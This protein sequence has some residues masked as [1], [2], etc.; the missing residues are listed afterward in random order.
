M[1]VRPAKS[2]FGMRR[3]VG[4][5]LG[6]AVVAATFLLVLPKIANYGDVWVVVKELSW[7]AIAGLALVTF[8]NV[9]TYAPPWQAALPGLR[10]GEALAFSQAVSASGYA[11]G[12][13]AVG[14]ALAFAML[15]RRFPPRTVALGIS[16]MT[17]WNQFTLLGLPSLAVVLLAL[18]GEQNPLLQVVALVGL[19]IFVVGAGAY[20]AGLSS[21]RLARSVGNLAARW[22]SWG[23]RLVRKEPVTWSGET[24]AEFRRD[25]VALLRRRWHI[26][27]LATLVGQLTVFCV[28]LVSLRVLGVSGA[29]VSA[30][31]AFAAWSLVRLLGSI[32]I[33]PGGLGVVELGLTTALV[34]FGGENAE[35]VAAV[36]VYRFLTMVPTIL[37]GL[38]AGATW[39]RHF[40][41]HSD[42]ARAA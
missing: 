32:P 27:T 40:P 30:I 7:P 37:L 6:A 22:T 38:L 41:D 5:A 10:F 31:E 3:A 17:I 23:R 18:G 28:L 9:A 13:A 1:Q 34:G 39:R 19:G 29:E 42:Q 26:L 11:P 36:L 2:R 35:V 8:L 21:R 16:L 24:F 33:T 25:S 20:A 4:I 14:L 15:R 12:G